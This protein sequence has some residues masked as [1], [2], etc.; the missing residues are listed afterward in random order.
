M[1][2]QISQWGFQ[3]FRT[4]AQVEAAGEGVG[5]IYI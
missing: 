1:S 5:R 4:I 2:F 3:I